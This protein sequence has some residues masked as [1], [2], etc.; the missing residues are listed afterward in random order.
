MTEIG[1]SL[2]D[3]LHS[4]LLKWRAAVVM[5]LIGAL[6]LSGFGFMQNSKKAEQD[7]AQQVAAQQNQSTNKVL[8]EREKLEEKLSARE[9]RDVKMAAKAHASYTEQF[10]S[11]L[12]YLEN[13]LKFRLTGNTVPMVTIRYMIDVHYEAV[14]PVVETSDF[15]ADVIAA[16]SGRM[17]SET[18]CDEIISTLGWNTSAAF[19]RELISPSSSGHTLTVNIIGEN[20]DSCLGIAKVMERYVEDITDDIRSIYGDFDIVLTTE[21]YLELANTDILSTR[22]TQLNNMNQL[23]SEINNLQNG[24]SNDQKAY[25]AFV[26]EHGLEPVDSE[27]VEKPDEAQKTPVK[28]KVSL[29]DTK[30]LLLGTA[31]GLVLCIVVLALG[32][33]LS[34]RLRAK[35]DMADIT[36]VAALGKVHG[37]SDKF[38]GIV[39]T[40]IDGV[41]GE[42]RGRKAEEVRIRR[43]CAAVEIAMKKDAMKQLL[44]TGVSG[45]KVSASVRERLLERLT[46]RG[47]QAVACGSVLTEPES[48]EAL[49]EAQAVLLVERIGVAPYA[50]LAEETELCRN[51]NVVL[52]GSVVVA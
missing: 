29:I 17:V 23:K 18:V 36:G 40:W 19:V 33:I 52:L 35:E 28:A 27:E 32:Y 13:S 50:E 7:Y 46:E 51:Q 21:E 43:I 10:N 37:D 6:L 24:M 2:R 41:F 12:G 49:G 20:K 15:T 48:V 39:D 8:T 14:Y 25:F 30:Y 44:I 22:Q 31:G 11:I 3:L 47:I 42:K 1:I 45:D 34:G 9:I 26:L 5:M 16:Y 4:V 38:L